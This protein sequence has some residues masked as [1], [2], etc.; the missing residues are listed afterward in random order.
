MRVGYGPPGFDELKRQPFFR[1]IN[2]DDLINR[3]IQPPFRPCVNRLDDTFYFDSEFT[4]KTPRGMLTT[5]STPFLFPVF[6]FFTSFSLFFVFFPIFSL[7]FSFHLARFSVFSFSSPFLC[8]FPLF[9][10][11]FLFT[12]FSS[13]PFCI[14]SFLPLLNFP[15]LLLAR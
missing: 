8:A 9:S 12:L 5:P 10:F 6:F 7:F 3:R 4:N 11:Y 15:S 14:F 2:W 13:P 1:T